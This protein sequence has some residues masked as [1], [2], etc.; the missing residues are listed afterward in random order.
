MIALTCKFTVST[1]K[2][3]ENFFNSDCFDS[4]IAAVFPEGQ[5]IEFSRVQEIKKQLIVEFD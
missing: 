4:G 5:K 2:I 3:N 1:K